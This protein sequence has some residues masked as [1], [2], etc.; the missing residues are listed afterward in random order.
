VDQREVITRVLEVGT[1]QLFEV[2]LSGGA[3]L[4][5]AFEALTHTGNNCSEAEYQIH[6]VKGELT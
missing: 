1:Q 5:F 6:L 4:E 2:N 3:Q